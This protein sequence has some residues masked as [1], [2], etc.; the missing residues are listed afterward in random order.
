VAVAT[1]K[2]DEAR[3]H[4]AEATRR[5][6][7]IGFELGNADVNRVYAGIARQEQ[8]WAVAQRYLREA[9]RIYEEH[10]DQLNL[11]E[12][13]EELGAL[14]HEMGAGQE[15]SEALERSRTMFDLLNK[16]VDTTETQ[17]RAS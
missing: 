14:L 2:P 12:V 15:A 13:Q 8:R 9:T 4:C 10:G 7:R 16:Q 11:A 3:T 6:T 17:R 1:G 5:F